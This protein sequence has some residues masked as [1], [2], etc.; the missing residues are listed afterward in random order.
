MMFLKNRTITLIV[1]GSIAAFKAPE[2]IRLLKKDGARVIPVLTK[3]GAQFVTPLT[4][5]ALAQEEVAQDLFSLAQESKMGHIALARAADLI[6][7]APA[8]ADFIGKIAC[9]LADDLASTLIM[10]ADK[11]V[12]IAPA[13]NPFMWGAAPVQHNIQL[14]QQRGVKILEPASGDFACG[15]E[16]AGRMLE[17]AQ[18]HAHIQEFFARQGALKNMHALV[19][20]GP[21]YEAIDPVRFI[22]NRSSGKQGLEIARSLAMQGADVTLVTGAIHET[23][24]PLIKKIIRVQSAMDMQRAVEAALP[25]DVAVCAAAVAD[26]RVVNTAKQK[27]KKG[28]G[29]SAPSLQFT[30]NPDI[31]VELST[32]KTK[33]PAVVVGFAAETDH[34]LNN[35][36]AKLVKKGC[37]LLVANDVSV[38]A[39]GK[40]VFGSNQNKVHFLSMAAKGKAIK[41]TSLPTLE[42]YEVAEHLT[43]HIMKMLKSKSKPTKKGASQ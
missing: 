8:S 2:L 30:E 41:V 43:Q 20:A 35:A 12:Y 34:V 9:G 19:T 23:P 36:K 11:P 40:S 33:R 25:A 26:W 42:K 32:H 5:Q 3:G 10:A 22:G 7:V 27:I 37:D 29:K 38:D 1:S 16:G 28:K 24:S 15:E 6:V 13:M 18:I 21:T 14:L 39:S 17:P 4:L 31:L